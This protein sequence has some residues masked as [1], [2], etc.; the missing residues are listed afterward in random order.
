ML[1][2]IYTFFQVLAVTT[3]YESMILLQM[4]SRKILRFFVQWHF[5]WGL[6]FPSFLSAPFSFLLLKVYI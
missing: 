4:G 6:S 2:N 3:C 5:L 1:F